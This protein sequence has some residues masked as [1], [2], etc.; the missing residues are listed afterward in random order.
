MDERR[1]HHASEAICAVIP[2]QKTPHGKQLQLAFR[3]DDPR[4][5]AQENHA[6]ERGSIRSQAHLD[7]HEGRGQE[8]VVGQGESILAHVLA[9]LYD[10]EAPETEGI[11]YLHLQRPL[12][13]INIGWP[14]TF[15]QTLP[16]NRLPRLLP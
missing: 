2:I 13:P 8:I 10:R 12:H 14:V 4:L 1:I 9:P 6:H 15:Q 16:D 11:V 5:R 7:T 3:S